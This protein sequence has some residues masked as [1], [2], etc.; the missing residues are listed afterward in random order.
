MVERIV[1]AARAVLIADGYDQF[2]TNR[3]ASQAGISPGSLYQYFPDK[4]SILDE[5]I[6]RYWEQLS[7]Q[8]ETSL[9]ERIDR[10]D[11]ANARA[12]FDALL[13]AL[14]T[15]SALLRVIAEELPKSRLQRKYAATQRRVQELAAT[16]MILHGEET[17]HAIA[18]TRAW[19][20]VVAVENLATRWVL[21]ET[22][23][24]REQLLDEAV[25]LIVVYLGAEAPQD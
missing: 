20:A 9:S 21:D 5:V 25:E 24:T 14:E 22:S 6:E 4:Q 10:F 13:T 8:V 17:D 12:I 7:T 3:V 19:I 11:A 2:T 16:L 23:I 18:L 1:D 15:D